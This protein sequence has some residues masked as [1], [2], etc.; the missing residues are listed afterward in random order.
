MSVQ[1]SLCAVRHSPLSLKDSRIQGSE[2]IR[3][4][5]IPAYV[6]RARQKFWNCLR[7]IYSGAV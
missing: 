7:L 5:V 2:R 3:A 1:F 6:Y 4:Y